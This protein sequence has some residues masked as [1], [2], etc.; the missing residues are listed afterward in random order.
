MRGRQQYIWILFPILLGLVGWSVYWAY[1]YQLRD[2]WNREADLIKQK[3]EGSLEST[4]RELGVLTESLSTQLAGKSI[5][6]LTP[7]PSSELFKRMNISEIIVHSFDKSKALFTSSPSIPQI[8]WRATLFDFFRTNTAQSAMELTEYGSRVLK[9]EPLQ[10]KEGPYAL[11]ATIDLQGFLQR[12]AQSEKVNIAFLVASE[13]YKSPNTPAIQIT[14]QLKYNLL[15]TSNPQGF[16]L[17]STPKIKKYIGSNV[18]GIDIKGK[19]AL[20]IMMLNNIEY[21]SAN[22]PSVGGNSSIVLWVDYSETITKLSADRKRV[23][24]LL[25]LSLTL[26]VLSYTF[27]EKKYLRHYHYRLDTSRDSLRALNTKLKAEV[28][29]RQG[30][31]E[32]MRGMTDELYL[33]CKNDSD[34]LSHLAHQLKL[35]AS[36]GIGFVEILASEKRI[37]K[38]YEL[39]DSLHQLGERLFFLAENVELWS[40]KEHFTSPQLQNV[41]LKDIIESVCGSLQKTAKYKGVNLAI[42]LDSEIFVQAEPLLLSIAI[43]NLINNALRFAPKGSSIQISLRTQEN[44]TI[45]F[46]VR[47]NGRGIPRQVMET[48]FNPPGK[49]IERDIEGNEGLGLGLLIVQW[50]SQLHKVSLQITSDENQGC[51]VRMIFPNR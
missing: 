6:E 2:D 4:Q 48:I 9:M 8:V 5:E 10:L 13:R 23:M 18:I 15:V 42:S 44:G 24:L 46:S 41:Q 20:A 3:L 11:E 31:E 22:V 29:I 45:E 28:T 36:A 40:R 39:L 30:A 34:L 19:T 14:P 33:R 25:F 27:V 51:L 35:N 38:D 32:R 37:G 49:N 7:L 12:F 50:V 16:P 21:R 43:K 17:L 47:D 1:E 26:V